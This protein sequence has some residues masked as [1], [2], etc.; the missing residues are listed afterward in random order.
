MAAGVNHL[1]IV[2]IRTTA[3]HNVCFM[4]LLLVLWQSFE[5]FN[6]LILIILPNMDSTIPTDTNDVNF[7]GL[8]FF[9]GHS[10]SRIEHADEPRY[11]ILFYTVITNLFLIVSVFL[12][13]TSYAFVKILKDFGLGLPINTLNLLLFAFIL[14]LILILILSLGRKNLLRVF[15]NIACILRN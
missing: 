12:F 14:I 15:V 2:L 11:F 4:A 3:G 8:I 13:A 6:N 10:L 7:L 1:N 9:L 5:C